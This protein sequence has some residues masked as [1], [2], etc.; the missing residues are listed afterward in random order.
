MEALDDMKTIA[1]WGDSIGKGI[2]YS[3]ERGRYCL[4]K[5]RCTNLLKQ[6]GLEIDS[7][8]RM[9]ATITEGFQQYQE[10]EARPG[11]IAVIECSGQA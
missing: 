2:I 7:W 4:A 1:L 5:N 11:S 6:A 3:E 9:G 8:A 10:T